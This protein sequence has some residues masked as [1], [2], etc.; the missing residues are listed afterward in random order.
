MVDYEVDTGKVLAAGLGPIV[1][2]VGAVVGFV[3]NND[4]SAPTKVG[5]CMC[6]AINAFRS[7]QFR[8]KFIRLDELR[9]ETLRFDDHLE[10]ADLKVIQSQVGRMKTLRAKMPT[11][12]E[13]E[14]SEM[15]SEY[16]EAIA[17]MD[18]MYRVLDRMFVQVRTKHLNSD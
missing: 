17:E 3:E 4:D 14:W 9:Q 11:W 15:D 18:V 12:D 1:A 16:K 10:T 8:E 7:G 2:A 13:M 5:K 6:E